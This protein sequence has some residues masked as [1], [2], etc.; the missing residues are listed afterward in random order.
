MNH[1]KARR[2]VSL[3]IAY[4]ML[5]PASNALDSDHFGYWLEPET[6]VR[7]LLYP[8]ATND[9]LLCGRIIDVP[10]TQPDKDVNNP[11]QSLRSRQLRD[12][13][14]MRDFQPVAENVW[15]GGGEYGKLPGRIYLPANGDT[16][17][18]HKN[19]YRIAIEGDVLSIS[20][21]NCRF[22]SC[23]TKSEWQRVE[24]LGRSQPPDTEPL[25]QNERSQMM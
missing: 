11:Q 12:L 25:R 8:C 10:A 13:E 17:G 2:F 6:K 23:F 3:A 4:F 5:S 15:E 19:R 14:I 24:G 16:L 22:I 9:K 20:V 21:A 18:D 1:S 7:V